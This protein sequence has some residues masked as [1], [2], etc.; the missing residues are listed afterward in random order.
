MDGEDDR[1]PK[2]TLPQLTPAACFKEFVQSHVLGV[3]EFDH[4]LKGAQL[5][6]YA[7]D[8]ALF[9]DRQARD[10]QI[11]QLWRTCKP[12]TSKPLPDSLPPWFR[13]QVGG[14]VARKRDLLPTLTTF[15]TNAK[16]EVIDEATDRLIVTTE[17][18]TEEFTIRWRPDPAGTPSFGQR[19]RR[20]ANHTDDLAEWVFES[21]RRRQLTHQDAAEVVMVC[22]A[23]RVEL[24]GYRNLAA[25]WSQKQTAPSAKRVTAEWVSMAD[26]IDRRV[27]GL[28][29]ALV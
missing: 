12:L 2:P 28:L 3:S 24:A 10:D 1:P 13:E 21:K 29:A 25:R 20:L 26:E 18:C 27:R 8:I 17:L 22:S 4:R 15:I 5:C 11:E 6:L 9:P 16:L 19:L 23:R 14:L 7:W